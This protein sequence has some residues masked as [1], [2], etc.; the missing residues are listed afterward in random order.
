MNGQ[1]IIG[2]NHIFFRLADDIS[3]ISRPLHMHLL[4]H[5]FAFKRT[6]LDGS[7]I[8]LFNH[9]EYYQHWFNKQYYLIG[10]REAKPTAYT[11]GYDLWECLP[12]PYKLYQEGADN[13]NIAHGLTITRKHQDHCDFFFFATNRENHEVKRLYLDRRDIFER[14]CDYFLEYSTSSISKAESAKVILPFST[15]LISIGSASAIENFLNDIDCSKH[16]GLYRLTSRQAEC[17]YHLA[18]GMSYK[19]IAII[20]GGLSPRTIEEHVYN[21]RQKLNCRNKSELISILS[22]KMLFP[23]HL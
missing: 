12:D 16:N 21:I 15:K 23:G 18:K 9:P 20:L 13:F 19:E 4:I 7:K 22:K 14:Y 3:A 17:A 8:Y 10:N 11:D 5:Y 1:N 6:Y 2:S